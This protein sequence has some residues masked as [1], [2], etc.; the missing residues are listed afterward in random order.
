MEKTR[1]VV[2]TQALQKVISYL[3]TKPY[4]EV[5]ELIKELLSSAK[6]VEEQKQE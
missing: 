2:D 6:K 5:A 1:H 3:G 4:S